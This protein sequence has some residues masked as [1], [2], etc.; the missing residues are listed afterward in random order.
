MLYRLVDHDALWPT[1][2]IPR[3][4]VRHLHHTF[5][6]WLHRPSAVYEREC[7]SRWR[8]SNHSHDLLLPGKFHTFRLAANRKL[9]QSAIPGTH[10]LLSCSRNPLVAPPCKDCRTLSRFIQLHCLRHKHNHAEN[11]WQ[12]RLELGCEGWFLLGWYCTSVHRVGILPSS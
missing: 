6:C 7:K 10:L 12:E 8:C 2:H 3:W 9:T 1:T 4:I 5:D 11:G